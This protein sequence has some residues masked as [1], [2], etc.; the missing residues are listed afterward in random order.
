MVKEISVTDMPI[1]KSLLTVNLGIYLPLTFYYESNFT[2]NMSLSG[3]NELVPGNKYQVGLRAKASA[4]TLQTGKLPFHG[5]TNMGDTD[6]EHQHP[7]GNTDL[8]N[9]WN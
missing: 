1:S 6:G 4:G 7:E 5:G 9:Y 2:V 3:S 8:D